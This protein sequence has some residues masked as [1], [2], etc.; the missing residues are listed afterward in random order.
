MNEVRQ[1]HDQQLQRPETISFLEDLVIQRRATPHFKPDAVPAEVL[2]TALSVAA[3]APSGYNF[4]P[5]RFLV[6]TELAQRKRLQAAAFGQAKISEAPAVIVAFSQREGWKE[7]VD[8]IFAI[9]A[10]QMEKVDL[11]AQEKSK[12]AAF[13]FISHLKPG[14][15][16]NRQTMI[17]FTYLMLAIEAQGWDTAPMEGFDAAA[18]RSAFDLPADTEVVALLAIGRAA[19]PEPPHPGRLPV[20]EI[21]YRERFDT[22]FTTLN[23]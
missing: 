13:D 20:S 7:K 22:P 17:A 11:A 4:Q 5:W 16:A 6:L 19:Q 23:P 14:V 8:E 9:R 18:V 2:E 15:W 10:S 12:K 1:N 3:Q 21:A